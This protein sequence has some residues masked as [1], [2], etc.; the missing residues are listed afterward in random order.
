MKKNLKII[1]PVAI[2]IIILAIV[3]IVFFTGKG[4]GNGETKEEIHEIG[5]TVNTGNWKITL[6]DVQ[7]GKKI[8]T[9]LSS[10]DYSLPT[11]QSGNN[12][13][14][15][16]LFCTITYNIEYLGTTNAELFPTFQLV[17][18]NNYIIKNNDDLTDCLYI[19]NDLPNGY[20]VGKSFKE[21]WKKEGLSYE[22]QPLNSELT[23]REVME[24]PEN[25]FKD[26]EKSLTL[27]KDLH[28]PDNIIKGTGESVKYKIR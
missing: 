11:D 20:K 10:E 27:R 19:R 17:F 8:S 14:E 6:T 16:S 22:F 23:V 13:K 9:N 1:I 15:G 24:V 25:I 21:L 3:G 5:E 4:G 18:D 28:K 2:V 26:E 12:A 7:Y